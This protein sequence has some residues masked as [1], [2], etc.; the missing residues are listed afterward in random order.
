M[1][2]RLSIVLI[3]LLAPATV[4]L[5]QNTPPASPVAA[6]ANPLS[7]ATQMIYAALMEFVF[8]DPE[9]APEKNYSFRPSDLVRP[10]GKILGNIAEAQFTTCPAVREKNRA[11]KVARTK[12]PPELIAGLR[13]G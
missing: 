11:A 12:A 2:T 10:F 7:A 5:A 4:A 9:T 1:R 13:R 8:R 6:Q 3:C